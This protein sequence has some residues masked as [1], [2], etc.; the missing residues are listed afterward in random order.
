MAIEEEGYLD[1]TAQYA[2]MKAGQHWQDYGNRSIPTSY[3]FAIRLNDSERLREESRR[4][5]QQLDQLLPGKRE[6]LIAERRAQ[7]SAEEVTALDTPPTERTAEQSDAAISAQRKLNVTFSDIAAVAPEHQRRDVDRI[8]R[9]GQEAEATADA[10]DLYR[11]QVNYLYWKQRCEIEQTDTAIRARKCVYEANKA[12]DI[13]DLEGMREKYE[14]AWEAWAQIFDQYPD[15][16]E[17][18]TAEELVDEVKRYRWLLGQ[19][20]LPWPPPGF[21]LQK[22]MERY[23]ESFQSRPPDDKVDDSGAATGESG[24]AQQHLAH[25]LSIWNGREQIGVAAIGDG[26]AAGHRGGAGCC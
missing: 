23:D 26:H 3:G 24:S 11:D 2:W 12:Y 25:D 20:E 18:T 15:M 4:L 21:K 6:Q 10:I 9:Q 19:L 22:L 7:L 5:G 1:E 8:V 14:Q 13:A 17:D 16:L